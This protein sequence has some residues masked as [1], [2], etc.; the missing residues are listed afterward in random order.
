M[1][2][3]EVNNDFNFDILLYQITSGVI[4]C[5]VGQEIYYICRP[6]SQHKMEAAFLKN[7]LIYEGELLG[8]LKR[9][10]LFDFLIHNKL[11][12]IKEEN[13]LQSLI[14]TLDGLKEQMYDFY[15]SF[16]GK[17]LKAAK[18]QL[19]KNKKRIRELQYKKSL[20]DGNTIEG[21][22]ELAEVQYLVYKNTTDKNGNKID[23]EQYSDNF[24]IFLFNSYLENKP[25]E[26][27]IRELSKTPKWRMI[28]ASGRQEG[29]IFGVSSVELTEEQSSLIGWSKLYDN[30]NEH[31]EKPPEEV[32]E[33][34]DLLDGWIIREN[35]KQQQDNAKVTTKTKGDEQFI[36]VETEEDAKRVYEQNNPHARMV[37]RQRLAAVSNSN[38]GRVKEQDTPDAIQKIRTKAVQQMREKNKKG[39]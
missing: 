16:K 17:K 38:T 9:S 31:P 19:E 25:T 5:N 28:W 29:R 1:N 11:W 37:Q 34:N 15:S 2:W 27:M 14:P 13:E 10:E 18:K 30:I 35:K 32:L 26:E 12:S 33:D 8:L 22:S 7:E 20:H 36:V 23:A 3:R 24:F 39:K 6:S 21:M 4:R